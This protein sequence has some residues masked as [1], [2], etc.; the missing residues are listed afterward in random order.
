[1]SE[2]GAFLELEIPLWVPFQFGLRL[3]SLKKC[4]PCE[5]RHVNKTGIGVLFRPAVAKGSRASRP[6]ISTLVDNWTGRGR[7]R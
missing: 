2:K 6:Q 5:I 7:K 3:D 1:M 4:L